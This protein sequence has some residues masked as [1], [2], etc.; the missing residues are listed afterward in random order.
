MGSKPQNLGVVGGK[1]RACPSSPNCV[2]TQ[3]KSESHSMPP[4]KFADAPDAAWSRLKK[5]INDFPRT[6]IVTD[7]GHYMHV[8]FRT[9]LIRFVDDVEF[10]MDADTGEIQ[11]RSAS[12]VGYSDFGTNRKRMSQIA[13]AF[14]QK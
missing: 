9:A 3:G 10:L 5:V 11:F 7:D 6:T 4:L 2:C 1:L 13:A 8:E 14:E 12:R